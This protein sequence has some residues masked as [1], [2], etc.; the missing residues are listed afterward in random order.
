[1][2]TLKILFFENTQQNCTYNP[3]GCVL[4][5]SSYNNNGVKLYNNTIALGCLTGEN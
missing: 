3:W 4:S 5:L 1:M 2:E